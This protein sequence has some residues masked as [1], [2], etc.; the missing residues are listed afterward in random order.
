MFFVSWFGIF[1]LVLSYA[2]VLMSF[3]CSLAHSQIRFGDH[4]GSLRPL[5]SVGPRHSL[6]L[7][8]HR[9]CSVLPG[10]QLLF[11]N[12]LRC[13]SVGVSPVE[14]GFKESNLEDVRSHREEHFRRLSGLPGPRDS[15][16]HR[17]LLRP[18][19]RRQFH[20]S[21]EHRLE[22][23]EQYGVGC[24]DQRA[25]VAVVHVLGARSSLVHQ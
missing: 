3:S 6:L 1:A 21:V 9:C 19:R 20:D 5:H 10:I 17:L 22:H 11:L 23:A 24:D 14:A 25:H 13:P 16:D 18:R 2:V 15:L 4:Q 7:F 12:V 8:E